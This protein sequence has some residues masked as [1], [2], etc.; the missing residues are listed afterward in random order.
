MDFVV[1]VL[2]SVNYNKHYIGFTSNLIQRF[3]AHNK[4]SSKGYTI[5]YRPWIVIY[6]EFFHTKADA[7]NREKFLKSGMGRAWLKQNLDEW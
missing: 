1:Y 6:L 4:L 7:L 5:K 2:K 3:Y